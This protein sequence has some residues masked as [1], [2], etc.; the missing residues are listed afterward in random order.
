MVRPAFDIAQ[1]TVGERL[2]LIEALWDSLRREADA[3]PLTPAERALVAQ[4]R[5]EHERDPGSAIPWEAVR[6]ELWADQA[7][8]DRG[9][10]NVNGAVE[11]G[12]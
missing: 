4:R 5:A 9:G 7:A 3:L 6:A 11:R 2:E 1:L 8:D 10:A 12:G